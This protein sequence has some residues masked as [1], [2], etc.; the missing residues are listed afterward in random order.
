MTNFQWVSLIIILAVTLAGGSYPLLKNKDFIGENEFPKGKAFTAGVFLALSLTVMLPDAFGL[1][2]KLLNNKPFP[3]ATYFAIGVF[4]MLLALEHRLDH[5]KQDQDPN[6]IIIPIIMTSM[7]G[8]CS[9]LLGAALGIS[10]QSP[11]IMV[12]LAI[13]AHKG[14]A[15]FALALTMIKSKMTSTQTY[16]AFLCFAFATPAGILLS[17]IA[18]QFLA[19]QASLF[20]KATVLSIASGVFLYLATTHGLRHTPFVT[21]C[22]NNTNFL[23]MLTGLFITIGVSILLN[24]AKL[25]HSH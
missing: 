15:A 24:A 19:D 1:W 8:T 16:I 14:S 18:H 20:F 6:S 22:K 10:K 2:N 23:V 11:A 5:V 21:N 12:F 25:T 17:S 13:I 9:F 7:I 3:F 4:I